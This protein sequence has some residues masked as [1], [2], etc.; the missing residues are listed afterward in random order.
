MAGPP[1]STRGFT[2]LSLIHKFPG[3]YSDSGSGGG[4][5]GNTFI[6]S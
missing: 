4:G 5:G 1:S 6:T 3:Y 2:F